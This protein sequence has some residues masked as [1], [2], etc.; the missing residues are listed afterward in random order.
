MNQV[1]CA[2]LWT[3]QGMGSGGLTATAQT[4]SYSLHVP[5]TRSLQ[6]E[7]ARVH[8]LSGGEPRSHFLLMVRGARSVAV[9]CEPI[10]DCAAGGKPANRHD[11]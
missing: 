9:T 8:S 11:A 1:K 10:C 4:T 2:Q 7:Q 6:D 3:L 5:S